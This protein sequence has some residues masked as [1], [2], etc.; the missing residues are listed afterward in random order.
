[1]K[2]NIQ[3]N[4]VETFIIQ[5]FSAFKNQIKEELSLLS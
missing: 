3:D 2:K 1:M 5:L 4:V